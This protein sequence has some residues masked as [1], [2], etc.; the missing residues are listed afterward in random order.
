MARV[1]SRPVG[2][3]AVVVGAVI[4]GALAGCTSAPA[5]PPPPSDPPPAVTGAFQQNRSQ[6]ESG[7]VSVLLTVPEG[8]PPLEV[9]E[10][11]VRLPGFAPGPA[12]RQDYAV[13]GGQ[14]VALPA[15]P[16]RATCAQRAPG[17]RPVALIGVPGRSDPVDVVLSDEDGQLAQV[18][19]R[20]CE[21]ARARALVPAAWLPGWTTEGS[22]AD[23][24]PVGTLRLGPVAGRSRVTVAGLGP[25]PLFDYEIEGAPL[26]LAPGERVDVV[27]RLR[28]ARCDAH[29]VA[30]DKVGF[31]P[32]LTVRAG[33]GAALRGRVWVAADQ[34]AT[35]LAALE[36]RCAAG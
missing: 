6:I 24:V 8:A 34:R 28:A 32:L 14:S 31:G 19:A 22:G 2:P 5:Q 36:Q 18:A 4:A 9:G 3:V 17:D 21:A 15:V 35:P 26:V 10:M 30:E 11:S 33:G 29:A 25:T 12:R 7:E 23:L 1:R 16:G 27:V 20:G 13:G